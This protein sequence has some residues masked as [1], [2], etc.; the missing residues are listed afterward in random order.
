MESFG[1]VSYAEAAKLARIGSDKGRTDSA[2]A[3][4]NAV[5]TEMGALVP[6]DAMIGIVAPILVVARLIQGMT[7]GDDMGP[8]S[9][10][11]IGNGQARRWFDGRGRSRARAA[12]R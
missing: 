4:A 1:A 3:G 2:A 9:S 12:Q 7:P 11:L 10:F 5:G 6:S 8:A